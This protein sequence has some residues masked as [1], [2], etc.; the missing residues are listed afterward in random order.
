[1]QLMYSQI[2][3]TGLTNVNQ[4]VRKLDWEF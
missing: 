4:V 1:M 3:S 2:I